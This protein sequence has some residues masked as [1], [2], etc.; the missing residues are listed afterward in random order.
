MSKARVRDEETSR[1]QAQRDEALIGA[2]EAC[3]QEYAQARRVL[4]EET[5]AAKAQLQELK[6]YKQN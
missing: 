6:R 5:E 1:Q 3:S 2:Q 4:E